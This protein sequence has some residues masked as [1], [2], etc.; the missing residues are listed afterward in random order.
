LMRRSVTRKPFLTRGWPARSAA[1]VAVWFG[2]FFIAWW[3][4]R[5]AKPQCVWALSSGT[6]TPADFMYAMFPAKDD[7]PVFDQ[8]DGKEAGKLTRAMVNVESEVRAGGWVEAVG[9]GGSTWVRMDDLRYRAPPDPATDY[10]GAFEKV[11]QAR[12]PVGYRTASLRFE[13]DVR[14]TAT[15][16]LGHDEWW[17]EYVYEVSGGGA[18]ARAEA[19]YRMDSKAAGFA[20]AGRLVGAWV[21]ATIV[22]GA[23]MVVVSARAWARGRRSR[24]FVG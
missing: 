3:C 11:F 18:T 12:D 23:G 2:A 22:V 9:S 14:T 8:P 6:P 20:A 15:L 16:H 19:V 5:G 10:F 24:R 17:E 13:D 4:L 1:L 7:I 21:M